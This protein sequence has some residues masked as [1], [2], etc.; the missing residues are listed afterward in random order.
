MVGGDGAGKLRLLRKPANSV[1]MIGNPAYSHGQ[2]PECLWNGLHFFTA[3]FFPLPF[4]L[5]SPES[6]DGNM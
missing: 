3:P 2:L 6:M 1:L 4:L 5:Q